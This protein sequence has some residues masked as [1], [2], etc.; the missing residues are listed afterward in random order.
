MQYEGS[1]G[2]VPGSNVEYQSSL[3]LDLGWLSSFPPNK[4]PMA[5]TSG[6]PT[7]SLL[8]LFPEFVV[9]YDGQGREG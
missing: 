6:D 8:T 3:S 2:S 1:L 5:P 4:S 9:S 7:E